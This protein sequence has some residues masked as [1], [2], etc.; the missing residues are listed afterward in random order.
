MAVAFSPDGKFALTGSCDTTAR[1]WDLTQ[2]PITSEELIGHTGT[3]KSVAFSP[4]GKF[5]LTGSGDSTA[6]F[7]KIEST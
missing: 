7:W 5:A 2:S 4:D 3:V 1:F 6:R